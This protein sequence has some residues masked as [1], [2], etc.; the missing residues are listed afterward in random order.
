MSHRL[1]LVVCLALLTLAA[2]PVQAEDGHL[3]P[4][5]YLHR[6]GQKTLP[7]LLRA[8]LDAAKAH[9]ETVL[10]M[11]TADW[12]APCKE[13]KE[14][15]AGSSV[16]RKALAHARLRYIDVDEW[17]G[18]AQ[19]L[20]PG[21]D[22]QKLPTLATVDGT[23]HAMR[24]CYGTDLG[25]LSE[26]AVAHNLGRVVAG[27]APEKPFYADKP[28]V[29]RD[30]IGQHAKAIAAKSKGVAQLQVR[31][32]DTRDGVRH[33]NLVLRNPDGPRRWFL[34]PLRLDAALSE[35]PNVKSWQQ[36]RF[37][38]HVRADYL[39]FEGAPGFAAVPVAGYGGVELE[40]W[41]LP[42]K[43]H[44]LEVWELDRLSIDGQEQTFQMKLPYEL[45][46]AKPTEVA[47]LRSGAV[48]KIEF[49]VR[50][51]YSAAVK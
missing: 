43:G 13:I 32:A 2:L 31:E 38:E 41:P 50:A 7:E 40:D 17:R 42:G 45:K 10:L 24:T 46:I 8:E 21:V 47:V 3:G 1:A 11:F 20:L 25:L 15:V 34:V 33:V 22:A 29:E 27:D 44:N 51:R 9:H 30:L 35:H 5:R 28:D 49:K 23:A 18:P 14:F 19:R 39:R 4:A 36:D 12:C 6:Q 16:V 37:V 48:A 26:D